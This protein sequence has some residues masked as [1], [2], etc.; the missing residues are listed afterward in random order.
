ME[1]P[2]IR[3]GRPSPSGSTA[4][5]TPR[6]EHGRAPRQ[7]ARA[8]V[9]HSGCVWDGKPHSPTPVPIRFKT[10]GC[11]FSIIASVV[12]TIVLN[13]LLRGC[14][15]ARYRA[16]DDVIAPTATTMLPSRTRPESVAMR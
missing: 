16:H 7:L 1:S 10:S 13:L 6:R 12:L 9:G 15:E 5:W 3:D 2:A 14:S 4:W 8:T 11:L